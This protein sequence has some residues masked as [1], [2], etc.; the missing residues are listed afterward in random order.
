M[1]GK[2]YILICCFFLG[3]MLSMA[4]EKLSDKTSDEL[5]SLA[6]ELAF[7]GKKDSARVLLN[8]ALDKSPDYADLKI[9][10]ARTY[11][12]DSKRDTAI[13]LLNEVLAKDK[14]NSEA[15]DALTDVLRWDDQDDLAKEYLD[16]AVGFYPNSTT[17]LNK[18]A[19]YLINNEEPE[20]A[21]TLLNQVLKIDPGNE[22]A[23]D[24]LKSIKNSSIK[25]FVNINY[26][27]DI[28]A[29][30]FDQANFGSLS[31]GRFSKLGTY[32]FRAN[33]ANRFDTS[34]YQIEG[35]FYPSLS[36]NIYAYI[37]YGFSERALF[38]THRTGLEFY[39]SLPKSLE[40]SIGGRYLY[41]DRSSHVR[42]FTGTVGW[43]FKDYWL[44]G[45]VFLTPSDTKS[46]SR[47]GLVKIRKY[48]GNADT[49]IGLTVGY[50]FSPDIR[51]FQS[52]DNLG[53]SLS[54]LQSRK[55]LLEFQKRFGSRYVGTFNFQYAQQEF[56]FDAGNFI[57][58]SSI[59]LTFEYRF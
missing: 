1:K 23:I 8:T 32:Q 52:S 27:T 38:P 11:A 3:S 5:F 34:G 57:G 48:F 47:S 55:V 17:F 15:L 59:S 42:I 51:S 53:E 35:D 29:E 50:G 28:F 43:Y 21:S 31:F 24:L 7:D 9:F 16:L 26:N 39:F 20:E 19:A 30:V 40:A 22:K 4:Q 44:S 2:V 33:Y 45:R 14:K 46:F 49:Y 41:F 36:K 25:N 6:R 56:D 18:K 58:I 12:W 10:L 13:A 54:F 37:N